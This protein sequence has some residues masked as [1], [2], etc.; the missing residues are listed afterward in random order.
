MNMFRRYTFSLLFAFATI[1]SL[2]QPGIASTTYNYN[3]TAN[4]ANLSIYYGFTTITTNNQ[5]NVYPSTQDNLT[6]T[7]IAT[8]QASIPAITLKD[9]DRI[10]GIITLSSS[11]T[12]PATTEG[13]QLEIWL[14]PINNGAT[15]FTNNDTISLYNN[16]VPLSPSGFYPLSSGSNSGF[17]FLAMFS[18]IGGPTS[19]FTFNQIDFGTTMNYGQN[20]N[21]Q[22]INSVS[23]GSGS[24]YLSVHAT[25]PVPEVET[26]EMLLAGLGMVG[27]VAHRRDK[28]ASE[29]NQTEFA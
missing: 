29:T 26:Y 20:T 18:N 2:P 24:P 14:Q 11:W 12:I 4:L 23:L 5:S 27:F 1:I 8:G 13:A 6:L 10:N 17:L 7:N 21:N 15:L 22:I 19:S 25:N 28:K 3:L 9:G 16:G